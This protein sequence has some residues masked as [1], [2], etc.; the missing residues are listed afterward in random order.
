MSS[1][2]TDVDS[3]IRVQWT[4]TQRVPALQA[5]FPSYTALVFSDVVAKTLFDSC[6]AC[7]GPG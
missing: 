1:N 2:L 7:N 6:S 3:H 5:R 4:G